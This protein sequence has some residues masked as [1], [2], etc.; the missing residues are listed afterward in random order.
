MTNKSQRKSQRTNKLRGEMILGLTRSDDKGCMY[1][2]ANR[3]ILRG[4]IFSIIKKMS[5]IDAL[6][7]FTSKLRW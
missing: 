5:L 1:H 7:K 6:V 4:E 3:I 2:Y